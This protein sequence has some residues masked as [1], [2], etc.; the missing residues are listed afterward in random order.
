MKRGFA[1][2]ASSIVL[3]A[4]LAFGC[5]PPVNNM[6]SGSTSGSGGGGGMGTGGMNTSG[7][8]TGG[9]AT[10]GMHTGGTST[11]G[12]S[13]GG[14]NTGGTN[15]C[16]SATADQI[17]GY[18]A[19]PCTL[20]ECGTN[21]YVNRAEFVKFAMTAVPSEQFQGWMYPVPQSIPDVPTNVW[22]N[23]PV[24]R[25]VWLGLVPRGVHFNPA[26]PTTT[27]YA[28]G[29]AGGIKMLPLMWMTIAALG[30]GGDVQA[31]VPVAIGFYNVN[32]YA[33]V[34]G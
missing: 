12:A 2:F 5:K 27:C 28:Q 6:V 33:G 16:P 24:E 10:G 7:T 19:Q 23:E 17:A 11:G 8:S 26:D 22:F 15:P 21:N 34:P 4:A 29:M 30:N 13:T 3:A 20:V 14:M 9:M 31:G 18:F 1:V 25:A 32:Y